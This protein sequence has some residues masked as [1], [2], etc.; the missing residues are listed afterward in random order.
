MMEPETT[1]QLEHSAASSI[2]LSRDAKGV[3][4]WTIKACF[5]LDPNAILVLESSA[6]RTLHQLRKIDAILRSQY[7]P[8]KLPF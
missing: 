6:D 1:Q 5:E 4:R 8:D 2:E 7:A 3:Y